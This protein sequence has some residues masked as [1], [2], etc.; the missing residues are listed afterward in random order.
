[1][2]IHHH[3]NRLKER[4]S[5]VRERVAVGVAGGITGLVALAWMVAMTTSGAFILAPSRV[6]ESALGTGS[7]VRAAVAENT[8]NVS[9][10]IGAAG[11]AFGAT[12]TD[13]ALTIVNLRTTSTADE[14]AARAGDTV[15]N[16]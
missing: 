2:A 6:A 14:S 5:H 7:D 15:I 8:S 13:P 11:A 4:P 16:F 3:I 9:Q 12:T 10:L 1:M